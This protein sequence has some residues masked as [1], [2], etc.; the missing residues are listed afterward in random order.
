MLFAMLRLTLDLA[1]SA[2]MLGTTPDHLRAMIERDRP[3]GIVQFNGD[4]RISIFTLAQ[5]L[6]TTPPVLLDLLE[7]EGL[8][9]FMDAV[10]SDERLEGQ[11]AWDAY[12]QYLAEEQA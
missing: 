10:A 2:D 8:A 6:N 1:A 11:A 7:D 4:W 12:Q 5:I 9:F 3:A